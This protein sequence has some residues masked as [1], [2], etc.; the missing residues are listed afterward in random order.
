[1]SISRQKIKNIEKELE[2]IRPKN[3]PIMFMDKILLDKYRIDNSPD[4]V[5]IAYIEDGKTMYLPEKD[6]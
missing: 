4:F 5:K 1:M 2:K 3:I 6:G